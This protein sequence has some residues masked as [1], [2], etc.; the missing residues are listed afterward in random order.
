M[1]AQDG[2][3]YYAQLESNKGLMRLTAPGVET[4]VAPDTIR[5][6]VS[7]LAQAPDG[8]I[9]GVATQSI[10]VLKGDKWEDAFRANDYGNPSHL[11]VDAQGR[12]YA[13]SSDDNQ[14][15]RWD[16]KTNQREVVAGQ[17]GPIYNGRGVDGSLYRPGV[18]AID[19]NGDLLIADSGH[20]QVKR[21][22]AV[23]TP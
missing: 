2:S 18:V 1:V 10:W 22:P 14:V 7:S 19:R 5:G 4:V 12:V 6:P 21:V 16:P 9:Y 13:S 3:V 17:G 15:V 20:Q 8:T 23:G 11:T